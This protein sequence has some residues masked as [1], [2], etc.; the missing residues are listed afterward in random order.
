MLTTLALA[1]VTATAAPREVTVYNQG[2]ALVKESRTISLKKG[3]QEIAIEDVP[4]QIQPTSVGIR[5]MSGPMF[6]VLEQNYQFDLI[7]PAAILNKAVGKK[8][9]YVRTVA[10]KRDVLEG[11]LLSSPTSVVPNGEGQNYVYNGMVIR[12]DDGRIV[13]N[14]EGEI[15]V[16]EIPEGL[17][18]VPT[19]KWDVLSDDSGSANMELS[20][21]TNGM[22]WEA[23]YV[24]VLGDPGKNSNLQGWVS[25]T[26][27]SGA[28]YKDATL[29]L[30][31]GDVNVVKQRFMAG[32]AS[33]AKAQMAEDQ[34]GLG[35]AEQ[36]LFEYHLYTLQRP[37]TIRNNEIKQLSLLESSDIHP[38]K[39]ILIDSM[40][41]FGDYYP[42]EGEVGTGKITPLVKVEFK[43]TKE[44]GLDM[45]LPMGK[46]R[47][48][49]RDKSGSVQMLGEDQIQHTPRKETVSLTVGRVFDIVA[50]RTRKSY[51]RLSS[52][53]YEETFE[54]EVR[55]RKE[56]AEH[57]E[58]IERHW[59]DWKITDE[60]MAHTKP[61]AF[62]AKF[63][64]DL[65][66]NET[67]TIRYT[68]VT[69]W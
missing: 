26:N 7:S 47:I 54:I 36:Q 51:H 65:A 56:T 19:L 32:A 52:T 33:R 10:G 34:S 11:T 8:V 15:E 45:P 62:V 60:N 6:S 9:R 35:F 2:F 5:P 55:N 53:A 25:M 64:L 57:A 41:D 23:N 48:Y 14:P 29:K 67:K 44:N 59:G 21:L 18:S 31:A 49:Q 28:T 3:R 43:N 30:L 39:R 24:L 1:F 68:V 27:N 40:A 50:N 37:A 38:K 42:S 66:A 46:F 20:Y 22:S 17:I 58:V 12:T 61:S 63:D 69:R 13:L 16:A 4:S